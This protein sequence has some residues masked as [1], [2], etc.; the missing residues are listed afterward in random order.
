MHLEIILTAFA[1][2]INIVYVYI[3][4]GLINTTNQPDLCHFYSGNTSWARSKHRALQRFA[5]VQGALPVSGKVI[6]RCGLFTFVSVSAL[7]FGSTVWSFEHWRVQSW[8]L[9][10]GH[11][12]S[13]DR[14]RFPMQVRKKLESLLGR[15]FQAK[16]VF[17]AI[18]ACNLVVFVGHRSPLQS[19]FLRYFVNSPYGPTPALSMLL[20]VFSHHSPFHLAINMYV[21]HS[22]TPTLINILGPGDFIY[23]FVGG[24][25]FASF[26][27]I[28]NKS[29]RRSVVPSLGSSGGVCAVLGAF[30]LLQPNAHLCVP[31]VV[32]V[33]PH[34]FQAQSAVWC[35]FFL[36]LMGSIFLSARS[37][38]DHAAHMGGLLFG[39]YYSGG[40]MDAIW[41]RRNTLV[42]QWRKW[43]GE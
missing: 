8:R 6:A 29:I 12:V 27:S 1:N 36:E 9:K 22:F 23:L 4:Y 42:S 16:D 25:I 39:M 14:L 31:F 30:C 18:V 24:G 26:L 3:L 43:R 40:G 37:P 5:N 15:P 32:E 21:L 41:K 38:I 7:L 10:H 13:G 35:L 34:S 28:I 19:M 33:F 11:D 17:W 20:S 2:T